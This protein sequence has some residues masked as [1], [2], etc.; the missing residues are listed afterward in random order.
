MKNE[1]HVLKVAF[2]VKIYF[3]VPERRVRSAPGTSALLL[4]VGDRFSGA[5]DGNRNYFL[6]GANASC[7]LRGAI[8]KHDAEPFPL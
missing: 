3:S 6:F 8:G 4:P 7:T 5:Q 1:A 2:F